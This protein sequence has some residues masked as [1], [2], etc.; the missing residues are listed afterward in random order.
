MPEQRLFLRSENGTR[1]VR[2]RPATQLAAMGGTA[3][4]F[5]WS[6][7]ASAI[8]VT[9]AISA[10][11]AKD[12]TGR[13]QLAFE[14]RLDALSAE[15]D[16]RANEASAAQARFAVALEQVSQM[17]SQ[18]LTSE[19]RRHELETGLGVVQ[20][21]LQK[22]L[23][24]QDAQLRTAS[25]NPAETA[26]RNEEFSVALDILS[27]ELQGVASARDKAETEAQE[28]QLAAERLTVERD[29]IVARQDEIL[30]Q[31]EDAV[32]VSVEPLDKMFKSVGIDPDKL[33][34]TVRKGYSGQ[35][36][37]LTPIAYSSHGNAAI[38]QSE[39]RGNQILVS[40][41]KVNT[42]RIAAEK[43]PL[44]MPVQ[45]AFRYTSGFGA[46]WSRRHEGIDMA[47]PVGTPIYAT[48]DGVVIFAGWQRGYGNVIKVQHELGTETRYGHLSKIHV[49]A[50]QRVS[51]GA[52]IGDMGNTGR[53]TGPHLHYEV[54][55]NG[56]A[57]NPLSFIKAAQNVF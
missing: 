12:Q 20:A 1:F 31:I 41:D 49:R 45:S 57:V 50:G 34:S 23:A 54:R 18:L 35:G 43:L 27:G 48:G 13:A 24:E 42:Y 32:T 11:S 15:R 2:L 55:V 10:G 26:A 21:N 14:Q 30:A 22:A 17:Q 53:S 40:L 6:I 3:L 36:G 8:L 19:E 52:R 46:R 56:T 38:T 29:A 28:A 25:A 39:T 16:Q 7:I 5:G 47:A 4:V 9:D 33:L 37:P 51:R 44:S